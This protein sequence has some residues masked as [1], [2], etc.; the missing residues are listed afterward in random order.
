MGV[1][2]KPVALALG[3]NISNFD[4]GNSTLSN[5]LIRKALKNQVSGGSKTFVIADDKRVVGYYALASGSVERLLAPKNISR[6]MPEPIPVMVLGR[7]AV[8][9]EYQ[10]QSLGKGLLKDALLRCKSVAENVGV[11]AVLVHAI[12]EQAKMFYRQYGFQ[13]SPIDD[14]TLFIAMKNIHTG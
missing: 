7:L 4:C 11:R 2:K 6:N 8:D 3:H 5:W 14:M 1:I 12:S 10:G 9:I 13:E